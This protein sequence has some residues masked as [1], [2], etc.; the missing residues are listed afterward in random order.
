MNRYQLGELTWEEAKEQI[1][2][3][4]YL[5]LPAGS[6]EQH[7]LH[8]PLLTDS[9]RAEGIT[10]HLL[11]TANSNGLR[12]LGL[13]TLFYGFS[14][15][16][17]HFPGTITLDF[18][19]YID[20]L[21]DIGES[22]SN[23]GAKR[24][25][26]IN[27]HGGNRESITLAG[28]RIQREFDLD[29]HMIHWTEYARTRIIEWAKSEDW[30]H[31]CEHETSMILHFRPDLVREHKIKKQVMKHAPRT[32]LVRYYEDYYPLGGRGDPTKSSAEFA[33]RL[34]DEVN[35]EIVEIL[36]RDLTLTGES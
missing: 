16:H 26:V 8:L 10:A 9:L 32:R 20:V 2:L 28:N 1:A 31:S 21:T 4:D 27:F 11:R 6:V 22:L 3:A 19:T 29:F 24:F 23:H 17:L 34:I 30:G 35:Q 12:M 36:K 7:S 13:P 15:H 25:L 18:N 33:A 5:V 14:D